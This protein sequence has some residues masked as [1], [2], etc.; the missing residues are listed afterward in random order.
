MRSPHSTTRLAAG[1]PT[2]GAHLSRR[3]RCRPSATAAADD[4]SSWLGRASTTPMLLERY[5]AIAVAGSPCS[6]AARGRRP[7]AERWLAAAERSPPTRS[8]HARLAVLRACALPGR[9]RARCSPTRAGARR[10]ARRR[11][12]AGLACSSTRSA[13]MMLGDN[14]RPTSCFAEAV[15]R[16]KRTAPQ[17]RGHRSRERAHA[18]LEGATTST[19]TEAHALVD[20]LATGMLDRSALVRD[21]RGPRACRPAA[22]LGGRR[23]RCSTPRRLTPWLTDAI[24]WLSVQTRLE[25]ARRFVALRDHASAR[26]RCSTRSTRSSRARPRPRRAGEQAEALRAS[27]AAPAREPG[28]DRA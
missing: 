20:W 10:A 13:N 28:R 25:L 18:A 21:G 15:A 9:R 12:V 16:A 3:S 24:P 4:R 27:L 23:A 17:I 7:H 6:R 2:G 22:R 14:A 11:R 1:T 5:P 26:G 19:P 8:S